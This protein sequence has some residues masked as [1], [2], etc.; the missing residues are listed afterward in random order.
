VGK[1]TAEGAVPPR[2]TPVFRD[3]DDLPAGADL[4]REVPVSRLR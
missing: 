2:L 3:R 4:T 1:E